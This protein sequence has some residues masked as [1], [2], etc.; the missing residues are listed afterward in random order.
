[1]TCCQIISLRTKRR[2]YNLGVPAFAGVTKY[3]AD[4]ATF[5]PLI[6]AIFTAIVQGKAAI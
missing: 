6:N 2:A 4:R 5:P 1:M 3:G